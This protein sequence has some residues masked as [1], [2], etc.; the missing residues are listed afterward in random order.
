M[1]HKAEN[2]LFDVYSDAKH[3]FL[4]FV[5]ITIEIMKILSKEEKKKD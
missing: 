1:I 2:G 4:N 3:L 5:K